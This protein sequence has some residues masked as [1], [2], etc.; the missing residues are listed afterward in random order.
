M[1]TS[2]SGTGS[3]RRNFKARVALFGYCLDDDPFARPLVENKVVR[4]PWQYF[5]DV[6]FSSL[7]V[8]YCAYPPDAAILLHFKDIKG[9][10]HCGHSP[11]RAMQ[12]ELLVSTG[13]IRSS[14]DPEYRQPIA[15][16]FATIRQCGAVPSPSGRQRA[17]F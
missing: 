4:R 6:R 17:R 9:I 16:V 1:N 2:V 12:A 5:E 11:I 7:E 14:Q 13:K 10:Y 15:T 3:G 8:G